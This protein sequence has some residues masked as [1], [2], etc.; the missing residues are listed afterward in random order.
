MQINILSPGKF[1]TSQDHKK[2]FEYYKKRIKIKV[3]LL[4]LKS[5][6]K[7]KKLDFEKKEIL[8][9]LKKE[10]DI[11]IL[12]RNG[13]DL[14]SVNFSNLIKNTIENGFKNINFII[15][16][17]SGLDCYFK[18]SFR[19]I[20]FGKQT[21]PHLLVRV[22]LIEQLYRAFEIMKKSSYHK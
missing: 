9:Y 10:D 19:K 11:F 12:D 8:K 7:E 1:K 18:K 3:N 17:E 21:W 6:Q 15:G 22:M 20:G 16:S 14:T 5:Y 13:D 4:E 2:I